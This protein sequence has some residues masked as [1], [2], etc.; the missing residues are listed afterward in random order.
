MPVVLF[1][2]DGRISEFPAGVDVETRHDGFVHV[3]R[4]GPQPPTVESMAT[5]RATDVALAQI[6][7]HGALIAVVPGNR[8][9]A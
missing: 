5:F 9:A 2:G 7:R 8:S 4:Y 1:F 3:L 6:Y